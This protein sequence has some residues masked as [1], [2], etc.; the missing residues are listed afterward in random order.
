MRMKNESRIVLALAV[1]GSAV[2][3]S[4]LAGSALAGS[5][6]AGSALAGCGTTPPQSAPVMAHGVALREPLVS[7]RSYGA[8]DT[9]FGLSV[10]G[11]WA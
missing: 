3:G 4:V 7:P 10:P 9:A 8:A 1:A 11:A 6:L 5:A 2:A